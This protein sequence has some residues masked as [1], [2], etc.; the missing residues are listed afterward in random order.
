MARAFGK[1]AGDGC[2]AV[3]VNP[4]AW[5][6]DPDYFSFSDKV[7][8]VWKYDIVQIGTDSQPAAHFVFV[9][10]APVEGTS[11]WNQVIVDQVLSAGGAEVQGWTLAQTISQRGAGET[12]RARWT[13]SEIWNM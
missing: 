6:I 4:G 8:A 2:N 12:V 5:G 3:T 9:V 11:D 10:S 7:T 13:T 1:E